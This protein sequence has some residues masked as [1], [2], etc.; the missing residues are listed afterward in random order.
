MAQIEFHE[1][2]FRYFTP[3]EETEA[4]Q[5]VSFQVQEGELIS[6]VGPS[7]CGKS[8]LLSLISGMTSPVE[9][10]VRL[11]GKEVKESSPRI[12]YMLQQDHLFAWRDVLNNLLVGAEIRG[13]N[14]REARR[15]A[16][17]L[18]NRYELIEFAHYSPGQLSGGMRQRVALIRTLVVQPDL[19]L[20]D[21]PFSAL[22]YQTRLKLS[23]EIWHILR[24]QGRT[25]VLVTHD[26]SEAIAMS[27]RVLVMSKRP[28]TIKSEHHIEF[29]G[30]RPPPLL[31]RQSP[32]YLEYFNTLWK[33]LD[34][35]G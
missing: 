21:E 35:D 22:D 34:G 33:E 20:L 29:S 11:F 28:G 8:T 7:G 10:E 24:D 17:D 9:G 19:L 25:A 2:S 30:E 15:R 5:N 32:G 1:V 6:I 12:G 3:S 16:L 14:L 4:L 26:L 31:A 23:D 27:D 18:L 13:M